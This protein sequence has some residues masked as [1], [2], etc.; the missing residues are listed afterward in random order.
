MRTRRQFSRSAWSRWTVPLL[1]V[2]IGG[3]VLPQSSA[4]QTHSI[5]E[6]PAFFV[7]GGNVLAGGL[8]A[9]VTA[10]IAGNNIPDAFL[11]G[12]VGGALIYTGKTA[13]A[14]RNWPAMV[15]G[16]AVSSMGAEIV[17][18]GG[19]NAA[20]SL[21]SI[22]IPLGPIDFMISPG[23]SNPVSVSLNVFDLIALAQGLSEPGLSLDLER[24]AAALTPVF[25]T[26]GFGVLRESGQRVNGIA[27]GRTVVLDRGSP[28]LDRTFAHEMVHV[29]QADFVLRAWEK[30]LHALARDRIA[31][32]RVI[33]K[34]I[35]AGVL[36]PTIL[37]LND[38][39]F[40]SGQFMHLTQTEAEW[41]AL[42]SR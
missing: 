18:R 24:S 4:A 17:A 27:I 15:A 30:P 23:R 13:V 5:S 3:S 31:P 14:A 38:L 34:W 29:V 21:D 12:A 9:A 16:R 36:F 26:R 11:K 32:I 1:A 41:F 7:L 37:Q 10:A 6:Q 25:V 42:R 35:D 39:A 22:P 33:P 8:T 40:G 28:D 20:I 2:T 19:R